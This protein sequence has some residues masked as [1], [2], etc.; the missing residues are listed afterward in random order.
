MPTPN[1]YSTVV[2]TPSDPTGG[3]TLVERYL[4]KAYL[5]EREFQTPLAN[6][7]Y[8]SKYNLPK[9][10]GQYV[11]F[12]RRQKL[13]QPEVAKDTTDPLSYAALAYTQ[14]NVPVEFI[15]DHT[16]IT[17]QTQ[18]TSWIDLA[19]DFKDLAF[20]SLQR[21]LNR[22]VQAAFVMGRAQP[23]YRN[24][25]GATV[26]INDG[27]YPN[28]WAYP[29]ATVTLYGTSFTFQTP[30]RAYANGKGSFGGMTANDY[31]TM[32]DFRKLRVNLSAR[33]AQK[34]DGKYVAVISEAV[35]ADLERD[36]EYFDVVKRQQ[37]DKNTMFKG[38]VADYAG[39]RFVVDDEPWI[40]A[41]GTDNVL[42]LTGQLHVCQ[43]FGQD[44]FGYLRLGG[45]NA[46]RPSFKVQDISTT[47]KVLTL[48][49][50]VPFQSMILNTNWCYTLVGAVRNGEA[51]ATPGLT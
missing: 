17:T 13:R 18:M 19:K 44:A 43:V 15:N 24:S 20:E 11:K 36:K 48:G 29:E 14:I 4:E 8:G 37:G 7:A 16:G 45:E 32:E 39:F 2:G 50:M 34:I 33:G 38:Q 5:A 23:G 51:Y 47:G 28:F 42:D 41:V 35:Q 27:T 10:A 1:S 31:L 3:L 6:S 25:S 21:Y 12:T 49:Y 26:G 22:A 40:L 46:G 9:M 30:T